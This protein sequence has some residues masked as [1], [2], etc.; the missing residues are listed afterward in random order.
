MDSF[1]KDGAFTVE[2]FS[3]YVEADM[4][5]QEA[6]NIKQAFTDSGVVIFTRIVKTKKRDRVTSLLYGLSEVSEM[7]NANRSNCF[8]T[9]KKN[10]YEEYFKYINF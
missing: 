3:Q 2:E 8:R 6:S 9:P 5:I 7:E 4:L 10:N 1:Y